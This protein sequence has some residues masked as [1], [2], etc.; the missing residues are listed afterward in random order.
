MEKK[1]VEC[2]VSIRL[3]KKP[4]VWTVPF[5]KNFFYARLTSTMIKRYKLKDGMRVKGLF[6]DYD[7]QKIIEIAGIEVEKY[8]NIK[9][10]HIV[11]NPE[12]KFEFGKS[13]FDSLRILDMF[14][15]VGKG[16][17]GLIVSPPK[18]G[19][20]MLLE[21][22]AKELQIIQPNVRTI[23][24]LIDERP[25]EITEF[26]MSTDAI[27]YHS[28][29]DQENYRHIDL[30]KLMIKHIEFELNAGNDI[31]ILLDSLT[32]LGRA[33]NR[34]D[35]SSNGKTL[36]GG[37]GAN[38]LQMPRKLFGLARNIKDGGSCTILATILKDTG[39]RMDEII[40]QEFKG[41]GNCDII[42]DR[43]IAEQRIFPAINIQESGTRK[44]EKFID[45]KSLDKVNFFRR[46]V[47]KK[48]KSDA[49]VYI[50]SILEKNESN[51]D[52]L[53]KIKI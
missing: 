35:I 37:L 3:N 30:A 46:E 22:F 13:Q 26:Q 12:E 41:T 8:E 39:S 19:K 40:F 31:V 6:K 24:L 42:L 43:D 25:E 28:S 44:D 50:K 52:I 36:T 15:P 1:I 23:V 45:P 9:A 7:L 2:I 29:M 34:A 49:I 16:T 48:E 53:A 47:L 32:R 21:N 51:D 10:K 18:A 38:A 11:I 14:A 17:R 20:T 33:F 5:N 4:R 27:I